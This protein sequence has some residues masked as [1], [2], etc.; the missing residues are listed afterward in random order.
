MGHT[1]PSL[2]F[3]FRMPG[4]V[5]LPRVARRRPKRHGWGVFA[6]EPINKNTRIID[7]AGELIT[8]RESMRREIR[9]LKRREIWTPE[10]VRAGF[11]VT[12][13][14]L[15]VFRAPTLAGMAGIIDEL[16]TQTKAPD[17]L[18]IPVR[19]DRQSFPLSKNQAYTTL[20]HPPDVVQYELT[21]GARRILRPVPRDCVASLNTHD[22]P[23][24]AAYW[25]CLD[26]ADRQAL[27]LL[28]PTEARMERK[29]RRTLQRALESFLQ[30]K[31]HL[32]AKAAS[33]RALLEACLVYLSAS[34]AR[35][36]LVNLEDL[37]LEQQPQNVPGTT[38]QYPN[39]Q[40]RALYSLEQFCKM[41]AVL[42]TLRK[43]NDLRKEK[44]G[45][46]RTHFEIRKR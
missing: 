1:A 38:D 45:P 24:F 5:R 31:G 7:Y 33:A 40:R 32:K 13:S 15:K 8:N 25:Q 9:Y 22:M 10:Q 16:L 46:R 2:L 3:S 20:E 39:W 27:G 11:G 35:V 19:G 34:P 37:W 30:S 41:P 4:T 28:D 44:K 18:S 12:L 43:I 23:P 36:V 14:V 6:L 26:I 17:P 21:P 29:N 42:G